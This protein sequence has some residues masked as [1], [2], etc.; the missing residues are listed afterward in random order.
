MIAARLRQIADQ[1]P[2]ARALISGDAAMSYPE[3]LR[4]AANARRALTDR[5]I[6]P[7]DF[8]MASLPVSIEAAVIFVACTEAGAIFLPVNPAWRKAELSWLIRQAP[9]AIVIVSGEGAGRWLETEIDPHRIAGTDQIIVP[10]ADDPVESHPWPPDHVVA[11]IV[12]SGS[13]GQPKIALW[14]AARVLGMSAAMAAA[15]SIGPGHRLLATVPIHHGHGLS[16][17]LIMP[18]LS[19]ATVVLLQRFDPSGAARAIERHSIEYLISSPA[20]LTLLL[21]ANVPASAL[22]SL[23][24]CLSGGAPLAPS[25]AEAWNRRYAAPIR[26]AYGSSEAGMISIQKEDS[27]DRE[28]V[29]QPLPGTEIRILSGDAEQPC[30]ELGEIAVRGPGVITGYLGETP[31][32]LWNGFLRTGDLGRM[33]AEG[34]LY[35]AGR[36]QPW[37]NTGGVKVDPAEVQRVIGAMAGV[38]ECRVEG[39]PGPGGM[40]IVAAV[41]APEPGTSLTRAAVIQHCRKHLAEFK[42]PRVVRF[43]TAIAA[44]LGGKSPRPWS[45]ELAG[46]EPRSGEPA[47]GEHQHQG[48]DGKA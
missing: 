38:R 2:E 10:A 48:R 17:S 21:D 6:R 3:L 47:G 26:Q 13:M 25:V 20:V 46:L 31:V 42:I 45:E 14:T 8:V 43:T 36:L 5:G 29:G 23:R 12:T 30:G 27:A 44:D 16:N 32:R 28:C 41:I 40:E 4:A 35:V 7:G 33:D 19:G 22:R 1:D 34:K 39:E 37:I 18:L 9:P 24:V 11:A 15:C